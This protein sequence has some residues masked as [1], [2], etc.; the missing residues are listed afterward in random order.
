MKKNLLRTC[1]GLA[2]GG[3][4]LI[5]STVMSIASGPTGYEVLKA[6]LKNSGKIENATLSISGSL[7]DN[8]KEFMN[9]KST[10]KA[11]SEQ[12]ISGAISV[13]TGKID[14]SYTFFGSEGNVIFKDDDAKVYNRF[15]CNEKEHGKNVKK[16]SSSHEAHSNPQME[17]ICENIIDTLVGNL[18]NQV[19]SD[20]IGD[21]Q[22]LISINLDKSE[23][24]AVFNM[25]LNVKE[26]PE[27][28]KKCIK[29]DEIKKILGLSPEDF[30]A[31]E[32]TNNVQAEEIDVNMVV[33]KNNIIKKM[34]LTIE[35][36]GDDDQNQL[37][38]QKLT[39]SFDISGINSTS[40]DTIDLSGEEVMEITSE[41]FNL[42]RE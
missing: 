40:V 42:T 17:A 10:L 41:D 28:D 23:I 32:L 24:P 25:L 18:K 3:S 36:T 27:C 39:L 16:R 33:D 22:K 20:N 29:H 2:V 1:I 12:F 30:N 14:K 19:T 21:G 31:P 26:D 13:D 8:D 7:T 4:L 5:T 9:V 15:T 35:V 11:E 34:D 37:H 6:A 38:N